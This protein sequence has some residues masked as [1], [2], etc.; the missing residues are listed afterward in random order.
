MLKSVVTKQMPPIWQPEKLRIGNV[1]LSAKVV[2]KI[3]ESVDSWIS[4]SSKFSE[5]RSYYDLSKKQI[6]Y[7]PID[8]YYFGGSP[9]KNHLLRIFKVATWY[10]LFQYTKGI[11]VAI[12][13]AIKIGY[14]F[15]TNQM[16]ILPFIEF[17]NIKFSLTD[18]ISIGN[19]L[20]PWFE[21]HEDR[22]EFNNAKKYSKATPDKKLNETVKSIIEYLSDDKIACRVL[23]LSSLSLPKDKD[24]V[25]LAI[26]AHHI[27]VQSWKRR[28]GMYV[29]F[30]VNQ[31]R[32][33]SNDSYNALREALNDSPPTLNL[34]KMRMEYLPALSI[35]SR[36][37]VGLDPSYNRSLVPTN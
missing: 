28:L 3:I 23:L 1:T 9:I 30:C 29:D 8:S 25:P 36:L 4:L 6:V 33:I 21:S 7:I 22:F 18:K 13:L 34:I 35:Y 31:N 5:W 27:L 14:K 12:A 37:K 10:L 19:Q 2:L 20:V 11:P 32:L 26:I 17:E 24:Q 16:R 15:I